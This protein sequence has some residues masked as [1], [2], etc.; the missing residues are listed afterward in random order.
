MLPAIT[1]QFCWPLTDH[2]LLFSAF[3][4]PYSMRAVWMW[5]NCIL[6]STGT[7][8]V[9]FIYLCCT[10]V[11]LL[12]GLQAFSTSQLHPQFTNSVYFE[13]TSLDE[14]PDC[15]WNDDVLYTEQVFKEILVA[16][17]WVKEC[18]KHWPEVEWGTKDLSSLCV[19]VPNKHVVGTLCLFS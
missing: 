17:R 15:T 2:T 7:G 9:I 12:L 4:V 14:L 8:V 13:C 6:Y 5:A 10:R 18:A 19:V 3:L 11:L 16:L 1:K